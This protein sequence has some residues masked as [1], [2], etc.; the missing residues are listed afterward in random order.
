MW[1]Q[2]DHPLSLPCEQA[3][4][5][6]ACQPRQGFEFALNFGFR[7]AYLESPN[8][9]QSLATLQFMETLLSA[10]VW[11]VLNV[12]SFT[13]KN[14]CSCCKLS[15]WEV[16]IPFLFAYKMLGRW[17]AGIGLLN[18]CIGGRKTGGARNNRNYRAQL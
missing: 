5:F 14:N 7:A 1:N 8:V 2:A 15:G 11:S 3:R 16:P 13:L 6:C 18:C 17:K 12:W 4:P 10:P 9:S